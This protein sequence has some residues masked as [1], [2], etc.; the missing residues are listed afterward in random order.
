MGIEHISR[1]VIF[2]DT[3]ANVEANGGAL[4]EIIL[5]RDTETDAIGYSVDGGTTWFWIEGG[6]ATAFTDLTDTFASYSGLGGEFIKVNAGENGLETGV[7]AGGG[8][9][10]GPETSTDGH[11]AVWDGTDTKTLKDGGVV[12]AGGNGDGWLYPCNGRLTLESGVPVSASD[13]AAKT[14]L[15]F[16]PYK[17][18]QIALYDGSSSWNVLTFAELSLSL[19]GYTASRPYDIWVYNNSGSAAL[20]STVWTDGTTR[21]TALA[22]Q[23]GILVK[24]GATTRRYVGTIFIN[25]SGGQTDDKLTARFVWNYYNRL[26]RKLLKKDTTV[27]SWT[28]N[29]TWRQLHNDSTNKVEVITGVAED[30]NSLI[31]SCRTIQS[32]TIS[33]LIG[34]GI[35]ETNANSADTPGYARLFQQISIT[36]FLYHN[37]TAGHTY[38][39]ALEASE[40]GAAEFYS[41]NIYQALTGICFA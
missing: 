8:D 18:S 19:S 40:S 38:Y 32:D 27:N 3:A 4:A 14:T 39:A 6:G 34:I 17:G 11:L 21:A 1:T 15:Y 5:G 29:G 35:N 30:V 25:S 24:S 28:Y 37:P 12:P 2:N 31:H 22:L 7:P 33:S 16:C 9:V 20:E 36:A 23:N 13:Q 10:L 41:N 26:P